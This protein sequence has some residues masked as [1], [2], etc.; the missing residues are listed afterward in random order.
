MFRPQ[1]PDV[2]LQGARVQRWSLT[3]S[4]YQYSIVHRPKDQMGNANILSR[5][6]VPTWIDH[7]PH[8]Y[9]TVQLMVWLNS[10]LVIPSKKS[11]A[12]T[13]KRARCSYFALCSN[14]SLHAKRHSAPHVNSYIH[15]DECN[16]DSLQDSTI[17]PAILRKGEF[18]MHTHVFVVT[19]WERPTEITESHEIIQ[20]PAMATILFPWERPTEITESHEI[21]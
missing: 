8:P 7:T 21:I 18:S 10:S 16:T 3:L 19:L 20:W 2:S 6:P 9:E 14:A 11:Y 13:H 1:T 12:K 4:G 15:S 5:L 17:P